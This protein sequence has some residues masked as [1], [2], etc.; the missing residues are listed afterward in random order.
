MKKADQDH[1]LK[2]LTALRSRITGE[3]INL[4]NEAFH[5][6]GSESTQPNHMAELGSTVYEQD[7]TLR[8]AQSEENV[9]QEIN[10]AIDRIHEGTYGVCEMSGKPIPKAR[11][12]A[13]PW[14]RYRVECAKELEQK[15]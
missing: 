3:V 4:V 8:M 14:T 13:I 9:L 5:E 1:F 11:L 7:V 12:N 2:K 6:P 10:E 15:R